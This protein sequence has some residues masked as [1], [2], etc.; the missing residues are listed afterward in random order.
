[1]LPLAADENFNNNIIRGL[2][3]RKPDVD[4]IRIQDGGLSGEDDP[5]I[6]EWTAKNNRILITHD[7][8]SIPEFASERIK[9]GLAMPG[10]FI[11]SQEI[12]LGRVI[13]DLLILI[14]CSTKD[15]WVNQIFYLPL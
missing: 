5:I 12:P 11:V 15:E 13:N 7:V 6:L 1:M 2:L 8:E 14:E 4:I 3:L 10:V 9:S